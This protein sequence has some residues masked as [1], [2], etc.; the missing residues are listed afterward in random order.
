MPWRCDDCKRYFS[1]RTNSVMEDS[2]I[3][4]KKWAWA[5]YIFSTSLKGVSSMKLHRDL[6]I[7]QNSAWFLG[8]RLRLA[9][10]NSS[11][12]LL[13]G[14][15]EVDETFFGGRARNMHEWQRQQAE[16]LVGGS[17]GKD[18]LI[19]LKDRATGEDSYGNASRS[20]WRRDA[21]VR[22]RP[23]GARRRG[24]HRRPHRVHVARR[25]PAQGC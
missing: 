18:M 2:R 4:L 23:C 14:P 19:G 24:L 15:V 22:P 5:V 10:R 3:P 11:S 20:G 6:G 9:M 13:S 21:P 12:P 16:D 8:H 1:V 17:H 7:A 25:V